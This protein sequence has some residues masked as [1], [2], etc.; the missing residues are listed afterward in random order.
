MVEPPDG[1]ANTK[2][3]MILLNFLLAHHHALSKNALLYTI[4]DSLYEISRNELEY[5]KQ[6][7]PRR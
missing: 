1:Q 2:F 5:T 4:K 7:P 3:T 6:P